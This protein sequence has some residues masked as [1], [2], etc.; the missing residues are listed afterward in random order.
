M[1][2]DVVL[3]GDNVQHLDEAIELSEQADLMLVIGTSLTTYPA[4][5]MPEIAEAHGAKIVLIN[6]DCISAL[7]GIVK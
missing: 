5:A 7:E 1:D 2:T 6:E 3:Y 4:A